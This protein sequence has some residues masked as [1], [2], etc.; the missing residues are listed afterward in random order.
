VAPATTIPANFDFQATN[1]STNQPIGSQN[2]PVAIEPGAF[3]TFI[4]SLT[5]TAVIA[6]TQIPFNF[7]CANAPAAA[8]DVGVNTLLLSASTTPT[9]DIIALAASADPGIVDIDGATGAGA[10]AVATVNVGV[11]ATITASANTGGVDLPITLSICETNPTTGQCLGTPSTEVSTT[12]EAG[13]TPTFA[14]FA[15][16]SGDVAFSPGTNRVFVQFQDATAV[17]GSTSVAVRTQ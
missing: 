4:L 10:F 8:S 7:T 5:P 16:G 1:P 9:A 13:E 12:I 6:P 2:A 11:A 15:S 14:I 17:R 3:Q